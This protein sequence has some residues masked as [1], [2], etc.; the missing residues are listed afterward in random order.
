MIDCVVPV[1]PKI[2]GELVRLSTLLYT[3][4]HYNR[5]AINRV[6]VVVPTFREGVVDRNKYPNL[7]IVIMGEES[8]SPFLKHKNISG[9]MKQQLIKLLFSEHTKSEFYL[10]LDSDCVCYKPLISDSLVSNGSAIGY[11]E[12]IYTAKWLFENNSESYQVGWW[13]K[14]FSMLGQKIP[15]DKSDLMYAVTPT[16]LHGQTVK[17]L[18]SHLH[19]YHNKTKEGFIVDIGQVK[20]WSEYSLY[21]AWVYSQNLGAA[22]YHDGNSKLKGRCFWSKNEIEQDTIQQSFNDSDGYFGVIQS[23]T[24]YPPQKIKQW[25]QSHIT[26]Q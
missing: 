12:N 10:T 19:Q 4:N 1:H 26:H 9:Y 14:S 2:D 16:L 11:S 20:G 25:I 8:I 21:Y 15:K 24:K 23:N 3:L 18:I 13:K 7:D 5:G 6:V 17:A 22:L